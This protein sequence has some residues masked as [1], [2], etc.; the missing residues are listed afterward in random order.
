MIN[1]DWKY[2]FTSFDGR[3]AR[4]T[5]WVG[6]AVLV[7]VNIG[8]SLIGAFLAMIFGP[9]SYLA[10]LASLATIYPAAALNAKRWHDLGKSGWWSL[11]ALVPLLGAIYLIYMLAVVEGEPA[12][13]AYGSSAP[14]GAVA[15]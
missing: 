1:Q 3:I 13:N 5:F 15:A 9:L 10:M 7:T 11:V 4:E 6:L 12:D 2:L 8:L 14:G